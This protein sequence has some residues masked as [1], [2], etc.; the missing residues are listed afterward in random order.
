M[1]DFA[2]LC[3]LLDELD[4]HHVRILPEVFQP[5]NDP[6]RQRDRLAR[7]IEEDDA[8]LFV[9]ESSAEIVG[10]VTVRISETPNAPMFRPDR[11][12]CIDD[13]VVRRDSRG[14]GIGKRLLARVSE[15]TRSRKL[16]WIDINVWNA[17]AVGASF[18]KTNG[19]EPRYQ[20]MELRI[21]KAT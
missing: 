4:D 15:W 3:Q 17:N 10:L 19:F 2:E 18:F 20:R 1:D 14:Q 13:L 21:D 12:A 9:A 6:P 11:R 7:F 5:F 16:Q 8:E